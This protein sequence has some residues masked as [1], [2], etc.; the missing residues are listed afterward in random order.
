[1]VSGY[2]I[3]NHSTE[4]N[5]LPLFVALGAGGEQPSGTQLHASFTYGVFSMAAYA[6][7]SIQP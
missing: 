6:F 5:L 2:A 1:L 3:Q 7:G 4:E